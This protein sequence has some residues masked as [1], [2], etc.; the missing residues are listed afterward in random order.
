VYRH[1]LVPVD[2]SRLSIETASKA[3]GFAK[4]TGAR[5]TFF[6]ARPDFGATD[7]GALVR[8]MSPSEF[9]VREDVFANHES[10]GTRQLT[11]RRTFP[12]PPFGRRRDVARLPA[13]LCRSRRRRQSLG[14]APGSRLQ[15]PPWS[16]LLPWST[17]LAPTT[18]L[19]SSSSRIAVSNF[20]IEPLTTNRVDHAASVAVWANY[21]AGTTGRGLEKPVSDA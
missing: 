20:R 4:A 5:I 17:T 19:A 12:I 7:A 14:Q 3:V 16:I 13:G 2:D 6:H 8:V 21:R 18:K 1:I 15:L 11:R 10:V 9:A